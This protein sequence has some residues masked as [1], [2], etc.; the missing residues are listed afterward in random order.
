MPDFET[1]I[2]LEAQVT[3][4]SEISDAELDQ[5]TGGIVCRKAGERPLE[6]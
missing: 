1:A 2:E 4:T 5:V 6:F 3:Q